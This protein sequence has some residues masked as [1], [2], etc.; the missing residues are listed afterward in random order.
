MQ[1]ATNVTRMDYLAPLSNELVLLARRRGAA[2]HRGPAAGDVDPHAHV[3]AQPDLL[4]P[5]VAGH[6][7]HGPRLDLDDDLRLARP[8]MVLSLLR[9]D[10]RA[11]D[12]PQL[13]PP[14][15]GR[16]RPPRRL[17]GRR[18][19]RSST[20]STRRVDEYDELLTGQPIFRERT[21]GVGLIIPEAGHRHVGAPGRSCAPTGVAWDLRQAMPYLAYDEVDFDVI[22]GTVGDT[23]DRYAVRLNEI[24]ESCKIV[25]QC[26]ERMPAGDYRV[27][28]QEGDPAARGPHRR[29]DGGADPPLQA[30]H[31]GLP[32]AAGRGVR[33]RS[34]RPA[35]SSAA[36]SSRTG[37]NKPYRL[38]IRGPSFVNLQ[39]L[40]ADA[41]RRR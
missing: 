22:V 37:S 4:A 17:G 35:A 10:D 27:A 7:R 9:E 36:T 12:E 8:E 21:E 30:L 3:R 24:R 25:R 34:S 32:G 15:R 29:V 41:A 20:R 18:R 2:R 1:G 33:R 19:R 40:P 31:R 26:V 11:A 39:S 28:G 5:A 13:H 23:F 6:Q 38:H 16:R 14:R